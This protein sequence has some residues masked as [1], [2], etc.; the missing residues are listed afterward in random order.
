MRRAKR[1]S[2]R[3]PTDEHKKQILLQVRFFFFFLFMNIFITRP[4]AYGERETNWTHYE[5]REHLL[6][7]MFTRVCVLFCESFFWEILSDPV[8]LRRG[9]TKIQISRRHDG[10]THVSFQCVCVLYL[11]TYAR[12][13]LN[14]EI[15]FKYIWTKKKFKKKFFENNF[16]TPNH[17]LGVGEFIRHISLVKS[18][19]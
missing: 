1:L 14:D 16:S 7:A 13:H 19:V 9:A 11:A 15:N 12:A 3:A 2:T 4:P 5:L 8:R 6:S 17:F 18:Y 10:S